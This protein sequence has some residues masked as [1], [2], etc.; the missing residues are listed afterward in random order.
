MDS[1][2]ASTKAQYR[3]ADAILRGALR[4]LPITKM[5]EH[6]ALS[7]G[8]RYRAPQR[9]VRLRSGAKMRVDPNDYIDLMLYY[10]GTFEPQC[11]ATIRRHCTKGG[12]F[13][14]VGANIGVFSIEVARWLG[15]SGRVVAIEASPPNACVLRQ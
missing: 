10:F 6:L 11:L 1:F 8:Y 14:D 4:R 7:W 9:I 13:I 5:T 2:P 12:T 3:V 15:P